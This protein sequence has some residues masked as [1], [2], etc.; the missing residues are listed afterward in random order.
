MNTCGFCG[1]EL[2][3]Y[4]CSFCDMQLKK[5]YITEN[6]KRMKQV[7]KNF[8][9]KEDV[10]LPTAKLMEKETLTLLYLLKEARKIRSDVFNLKN[11]N[12]DEKEQDAENQL[13]NQYETATRR[14]WVIENIIKNR[15]GYYPKRLTHDFLEA[16]I[17]KI[18]QSE[19]KVMSLK[20]KKKTY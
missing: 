18:Y 12:Q 17:D 20:N 19:E 14:V 2:N 9:N 13:Y 5:E 3:E 16:Y 6:S 4:Y 15:L 10:L 1:I 11:Q 8:L 7:K